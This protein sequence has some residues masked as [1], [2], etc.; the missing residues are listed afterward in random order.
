MIFVKV[1]ALEGEETPLLWQTISPYHPPSTVR[2]EGIFATSDPISDY[3]AVVEAIGAGRRA[4]ASTHMFLTGKEVAP[5]VHMITNQIE[6]LDV[7]QVQEL[8][9]VGPRQKMPKRPPEEYFDP[10]LEIERGL[11]E[12]MAKQEALRCLNCGLICYTR[13]RYH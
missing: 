9:P 7:D 12:E 8:L 5:P 11:T 3:R 6:V 1:P 2:P 4:A 10:S 13:G